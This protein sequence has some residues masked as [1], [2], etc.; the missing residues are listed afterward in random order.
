MN[1]PEFQKDFFGLEKNE[2]VALI[3]TLKKIMQMSWYE[4]YSNPGLKWEAI[5]SKKTLSG[6]RLY[7]ILFF[8]EIS[9]YSI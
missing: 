8:A 3:N 1:N 6:S 9:C 7:S 2:Q 5:L 4:L